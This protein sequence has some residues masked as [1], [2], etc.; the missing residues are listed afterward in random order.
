MIND[1]TQ[2]LND[3]SEG[4]DKAIREVNSDEPEEAKGKV[5]VPGCMPRIVRFGGRIP[6][7]GC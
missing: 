6:R 5:N 2:C 4:L 1:D 3:V 7:S